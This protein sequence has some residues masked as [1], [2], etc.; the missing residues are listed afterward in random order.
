METR[1]NY[2][3]T[4][5]GVYHA[6]LGLERY[7]QECGLETSLMHLIKLRVSQINGCAYCL[8]MHWKDSA[9]CRRTGAAAVLS[10]CL[11]RVPV[12]QRTRAGRPGMGG[13][14]HSDH[15]GTRSR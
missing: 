9:C 10:G 13:G 11:A 1:L 12:L 2:M 15:I 7:L 4:A 5:P 8:D 14:R 6:M 3:T